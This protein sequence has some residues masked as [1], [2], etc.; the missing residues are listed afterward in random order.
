[1]P[2]GAILHVGCNRSHGFLGPVY[3]DGRFR[4]VPIPEWHKCVSEKTWTYA[5]LDLQETLPKNWKWGKYAH[6]DPEFESFTWGDYK[7]K[8]TYQARQLQERAFYLFISSLKYFPIRG[9]E[10]A[11]DINPDWAY[12]LIGFFEVA[13]LPTWVSY[14]L[15]THFRDRFLNNAHIRRRDNGTHR[16]FL[17]FT[18][19]RRGK[20]R[21]RLLER[22]VALSNG[23]I[24]NSLARAAMSWLKPSS[25]GRW[26][27]RWWEEGIAPQQ[28]VRRVLEA[29]GLDS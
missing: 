10:G 9:V 1:M 14:P 19:T 24:P 29:A 3:G 4:F 26:N 13:E 22:A 2:R 8:R 15:S 18:G 17:I 25:T 16:P 21:S 7:N 23:V 6:Y 27:K 5:D 11:H 20:T 28:G 12:Y